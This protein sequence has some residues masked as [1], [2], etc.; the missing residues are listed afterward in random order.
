MHTD[1]TYKTDEGHFYFR[2]VALILSDNKLLIARD[3]HAEYYYLPGGKVRLNESTQDA[4]RRELSEELNIQAEIGRLVWVTENFF[5]EDVSR[6]R[7]HEIAFY[8][9]ADISKTD[10]FQRGTSFTMIED[11]CPFYFEWVAV[12][13]VKDL[14]IYPEF[15]KDRITQLPDTTEHIIHSEDETGDT[16]NF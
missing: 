16:I 11:G 2:A 1:I 14:Y 10:L 8:Y 3:E 9:M 4:I 12:D 7:Y 6:E 13:Q 5:L 15:L